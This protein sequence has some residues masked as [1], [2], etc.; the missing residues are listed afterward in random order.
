MPEAMFI[1][2]GIIKL[3]KALHDHR[4]AARD[5]RPEN[6]MIKKDGYL[7]LHK[8]CASKLM[9]KKR[10]DFEYTTLIGTPHYMAIEMI[11]KENYT[12]AVDYWSLGIILYELLTGIVP[13]GE[14]VEDPL[15]VYEAIL[16]GHLEFPP[17]HKTSTFEKANSLISQLL[18]K[19]Q[20]KRSAGGWEAIESHKLFAEFD[21][22]EFNRKQMDSPAHEWTFLSDHDAKAKKLMGNH[23][24]NFKPIVDPKDFEG[25][26]ESMPEWQKFLEQCI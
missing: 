3:L 14:S 8:L 26:D 11:K 9:P 13:F 6:I 10:S 18:V 4:I 25:I 2:A 15:E 20:H 23:S 7:A 16:F 1:T 5:L 12:F 22:A 19:D 24:K 17:L 21:W